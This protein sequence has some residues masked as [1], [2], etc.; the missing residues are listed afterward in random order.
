M[1]V[2]KAKTN[3]YLCVKYN[4]VNKRQSAKKLIMQEIKMKFWKILALF[5]VV[6]AVFIQVGHAEETEEIEDFEEKAL[7]FGARK[8]EDSEP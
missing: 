8:V 3:Q 4:E 5:V 1:R 7:G 2:K 6:L